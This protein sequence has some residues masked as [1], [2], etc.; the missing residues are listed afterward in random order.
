[1]A[2]NKLRNLVTFILKLYLILIVFGFASSATGIVIL[3]KPFFITAS[4][5]FKLYIAA[6]FHPIL[7]LFLVIPL[8]IYSPA[9]LSD[10]LDETSFV[11]NE[12]DTWHVD[13]YG[14]R[15]Y[16]WEYR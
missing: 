13:E 6:I 3:N 5:L 14:D 9:F 8:C 15:S 1:M 10:G 2:F 16:M 12:G 11:D 7:K 4:I